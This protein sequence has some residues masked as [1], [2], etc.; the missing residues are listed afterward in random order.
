[1]SEITEGADKIGDE[2]A[3]K[4]L[5]CLSKRTGKVLADKET[6]LYMAKVYLST[7]KS[8]SGI[9]WTPW[10]RSVIPCTAD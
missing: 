5:N 6:M 10:Q 1:M 2:E 9:P 3:E 4:T 7:K 8:L